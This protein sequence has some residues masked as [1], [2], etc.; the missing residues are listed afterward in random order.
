MK[1]EKIHKRYSEEFKRQ[2]VEMDG[3]IVKPLLLLDPQDLICHRA[4]QDA[5]KCSEAAFVPCFVSVGAVGRGVMFQVSIRI[6]QS[7]PS[8]TSIDDQ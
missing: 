1:E 3:N 6:F 5:T 7:S 8:R 4:D 2:A